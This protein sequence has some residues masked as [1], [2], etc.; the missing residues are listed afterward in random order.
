M[1]FLWLQDLCFMTPG[2]EKRHRRSSRWAC[3]SSCSLCGRFFPSWYVLR[4]IIGIQQSLW[5]LLC[6]YVAGVMFMCRAGEVGYHALC[7]GCIA[8]LTT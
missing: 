3:Y 1:N 8:Y 4:A 6:A 2:G 5:H 7:S